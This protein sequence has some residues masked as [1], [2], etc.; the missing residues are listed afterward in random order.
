MKKISIATLLL[1]CT[2]TSCNLDIMP[3]NAQTYGSSFDNEA[4]VN[5][6]TTSIEYFINIY[7]PNNNTFSTV[8]MFADTLQYGMEIRRWNPRQVIAQNESWKELYD[9]VFASNVILDNI[10]RT[11]NLA[12]DRRNHYVGQAEFGLGFAYFLL[13]QRFDDAVITENSQVIKE[14][15]TSSRMD[16]IDAAI[17][18]ATKAFNMLPT[19]DKLRKM[20]GTPITNRQTASKGTCAA[21]LAHLYAWKG[22]IIELMKLEGDAQAAYTKSMEYSSMLINKEVGDYSLCSTPEELCQYLSAPE[23]TNPETIFSLFYDKARSA[24]TFSPNRVAEAF[25][26]WPVDE[27]QTL[28]DIADRPK[29][30]L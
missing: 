15:A 30:K 16:V 29:F 13:A 9:I 18:H 17:D 2:L 24:Q 26:S 22:S 23:K 12:D 1:A 27:T 10:H 11:K 3:E 28:A 4:G 25:V 14:Y 19:Y 8:G 5:A 6:A 21:L 7:V 20:D